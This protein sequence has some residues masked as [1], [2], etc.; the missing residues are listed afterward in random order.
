LLREALP[1]KADFDPTMNFLDSVMHLSHS[2]KVACLLTI[3]T[4][5]IADE[6]AAAPAATCCC[7]AATCQK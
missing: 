7:K 5:S 1:L 2:V 4:T 3:G 6:A